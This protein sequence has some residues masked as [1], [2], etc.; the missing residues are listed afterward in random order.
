MNLSFIG[1][2]MIMEKI[3]EDAV[4]Q[5][6]AAIKDNENPGRSREAKSMLARYLD[7][8]DQCQLEMD[9][10]VRAMACAELSALAAK[11]CDC[12]ADWGIC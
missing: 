5:L 4:K 3:H 11:E 8:A 10:Q 6:I 9:S 7:Y 12:F 1:E 2:I